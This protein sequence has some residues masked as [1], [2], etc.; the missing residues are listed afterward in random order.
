MH[1][2]YDIIYSIGRDCATAMY[3]NK[4]KMRITSGP[5]DWLTNA[6]FETRMN[7]ILTD[8]ADFLNIDDIKF[9]PKDPNVL[10]DDKCDYYENIRN[11][12]YYYHDF[13]AGKNLLESMPDVTEKY[14]RRIARFINNMHK[15]SRIL[16]IWFSQVHNTPND[17]IVD[18][19]NRVSAK[20]GKTIDFMI[21]EHM[22]NQR[23]VV[24]TDLA[25]NIVKYNVHAKTFDDLGRPTTEGD[26]AVIT[27]LFAQFRL[28]T[29]LR[30]KIIMFLIKL[31]PFHDMRHRIRTSYMNK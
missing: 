11:G 7:L 18:L 19:C 15:K 29:T 28:R 20:F 4:C 30:H 22:E 16:L 27:P 6:S 26:T 17:V 12:F 13:P 2:S 10:N 21:I 8:F 25:P 23:S 31:I 3:M 14:N 1:K 24:R 9:L 5:F